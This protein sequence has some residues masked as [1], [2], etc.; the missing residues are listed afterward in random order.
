[1]KFCLITIGLLF[2]F[3]CH[4]KK[5][6]LPVL[7]RV[8]YSWL[9]SI[10]KTADTSYIKKYGTK[11]FANA[12][13]YNNK[14]QDIICQVMKDSSDSIRQIIITKNNRRNFFAEYYSNGQLMAKLP[15]DSFGQYHGPS[16]H[17]YQH[18][19]LESEGYFEHGLKKGAWKNY[20]DEGNLT[21]I[22]EYDKNGNV[23]K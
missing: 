17:Y 22:Q 14:K 8:N 1:M 5:S 23:V 18:G 4:S 10:R 13:Y 12:T 21:A 2:L 3:G 20:D 6:A 16:K 7:V 11:K 19:F 15:L 9:D